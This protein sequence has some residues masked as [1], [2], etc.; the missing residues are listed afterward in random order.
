MTLGASHITCI[1]CGTAFTRQTRFVG[2]Y[3]S[4]CR[5]VAADT[6]L[7]TETDTDTDTDTETETETEDNNE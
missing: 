6:D 5:I 1:G 7:D 3:C 2:N 4:E